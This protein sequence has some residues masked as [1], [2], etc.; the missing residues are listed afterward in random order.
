MTNNLIVDKTERGFGI[1]NFKDDYDKECSL[2]KSSSA[3][4]EKI[5]LGIDKAPVMY[6]VKGEG[7][8]DYPL[9]EGVEIFSRMH[10]T[11]EQVAKLMPYLQR[12]LDT[13]EISI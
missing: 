10:L 2:Q 1:I 11:R 5:W 9:P 4:E 6:C 3:E 13:G 7:W 8:K 12:F